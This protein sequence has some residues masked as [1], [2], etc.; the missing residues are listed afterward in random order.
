M[1][2]A[3]KTQS[4]EKVVFTEA[5]MLKMD[6]EMRRLKGDE[7]QW[8]VI[9]GAMKMHNQVP[10][11]LYSDPFNTEKHE[12]FVIPLNKLKKQLDFYYKWKVDRSKNLRKQSGL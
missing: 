7:V 3:T 6:S 8:F 10:Y 5:E 11:V 9:R 4:V 12:D 2:E 1:R